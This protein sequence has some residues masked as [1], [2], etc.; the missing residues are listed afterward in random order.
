MPMVNKDTSSL[1]TTS[2][3]TT[4]LVQKKTPHHVRYYRHEQKKKPKNKKRSNLRTTPITYLSWITNTTWN[5]KNLL[6]Y[7][8]IQLRK[9]IN[10][11]DR[12]KSSMRTQHTTFHLLLGVMALGPFIFVAKIELWYANY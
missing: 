3:N 8:A 6:K 4:T 2:T 10:P 1:K 9:T 7:S 11:S 5:V 12:K